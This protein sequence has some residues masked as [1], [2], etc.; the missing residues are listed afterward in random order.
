MKTEQ[1]N[2]DLPAPFSGPAQ[3]LLYTR[4]DDP[5]SS[6]WDNK[7]LNT[8]QIQQVHP[9]FPEKEIL[10][11]KH[12][13]PIL[14]DALTALEMLGLHTEIHSCGGCHK[15]ATLSNSPV[16]S[17]HSWGAAIDFNPEDNPMGSMGKWSQ[18][19]LDVMGKH[20]IFCGQ[21]WTGIKEPMHFAMVDGE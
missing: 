9:W 14:H 21:N 8:W 2:L 6:G 1:E 7:W 3:L 4:Y 10:I 13:R 16:L 17:V 15:Q 18:A 19:F 11:H 12:F 5:R 20:G